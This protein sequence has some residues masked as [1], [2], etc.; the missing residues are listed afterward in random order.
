[1]CKIGKA[2]VAVKIIFSLVISY[3]VIYR[4][5]AGSLVNAIGNFIVNGNYIIGLISTATILAIYPLLLHNLTFNLT[6]LNSLKNKLLTFD[7]FVI[8][9]NFV[10]CLFVSTKV[11]QMPLR[12]ALAKT[13]VLIAGITVLFIIFTI[14]LLAILKKIE[15]EVI[16]SNKLIYNKNPFCFT[17]II[18]R[19]PYFITKLILLVMAI[20]P[21]FY[22]TV[23]NQIDEMQFM[24]LQFIVLQ[25]VFIVAF[26]AASK[27]L[28]DIQWSQWLLLLWAIPFAGLIVGIPLFF[29]KSKFN[30]TLTQE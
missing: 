7:I 10:L 2:L 27:R 28:R 14:V 17:G 18:S 21:A 22:K 29:V 12:D 19:L 15:P 13:G 25:I 30:S 1:M 5:N 4:G 23:N 11:F 26:Y 20:A 16:I 8:F 6:N 24:I 9:A 3:L